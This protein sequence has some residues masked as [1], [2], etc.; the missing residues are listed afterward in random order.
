MCPHIRLH[1]GIIDS[2]LQWPFEENFRLTIKHPSQSK[3]CQRLVVATNIKEYARP[4]TEQN[5]GAYCTARSFRLDELEREGYIA[6]DK[7]Q[8]VWELV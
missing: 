7:L 6:D 2:V 8:V 3:E 4:D 1:K 5:V